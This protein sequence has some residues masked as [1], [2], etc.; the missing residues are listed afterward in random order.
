MVQSRRELIFEAGKSIFDA[1]FKYNDNFGRI[2]RKAK[3][4]FE[5]RDWRGAERDFGERI[6]LYTKSVDRTVAALSKQLGA[7]GPERELWREVKDSFGERVD[8]IADGAFCKTYFN[9][10]SRR[11]FHTVGTDAQTEFLDMR[12][13]MRDAQRHALDHK[14]YVIW[15]SLAPAISQLLTDFPIDVPYADR[16]RDETQIVGT[17]N[18]YTARHTNDSEILR[19]DFL[20]ATFYQSSSAYLIGQVFWS[21]H[22][23][24]LVIELKHNDG[25]IELGQILMDVDD[26]SILFGFTRSYF[27]VDLQPVE[28]AIYFIHSILPHKPIDELFT[29]LGRVRQ[30][31]TER[32]RQFTSHLANC[33]DRFVDADGDRGLVMIV[34]TLPSYDLVFKVI[35]DRFGFPKSSTRDD[36]IAKYQLVFKHDRAGRLID[37][38]E[39]T[40]IGFPLAKF[41]PSVVAELM[42]EAAETSR[43]DGDQLVIKH[44]YVERRLRPLNLFLRECDRTAGE[45]AVI[46]YGN[47]LKDLARTNV[48][49]GDLLLKNFGVTRHGR[50]IFYDYDELCLV[51]DCN[52]REVPPARF[53]EDELRARPWFYVNGND[54]FPEEFMRFLAMD[55]AYRESFLRH[56]ADLLTVEF[57]R[58][59]KQQHLNRAA[60]AP[61]G[62]KTGPGSRRLAAR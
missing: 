27:F 40:H 52:F 44:L 25:G 9:S 55:D 60:I 17:L 42:S 48:F 26:I 6:E 22:N 30:G 1:F 23:S 13:N 46:D 7:L 2:T 62:F 57:W 53:E 51:T 54:I 34:F 16:A 19:L 15:E 28:G 58:R 37:T 31:K 14:S 11:L 32:Y 12:F 3:S 21:N 36:V 8:G 39:F 50:V 59:I 41:D 43:I 20:P 49:P 10:V 33:Q 35:R 24:P 29:V 4:R 56:H 5:N 18:A 45:A 38:Q 61:S 47:A